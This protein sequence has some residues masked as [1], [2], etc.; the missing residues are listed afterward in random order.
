MAVGLLC[1]FCLPPPPFSSPAPV[2]LCV[3]TCGCGSSG[4][5]HLQII[6]LIILCYIT[7]VSSPLRCQIVLPVTV[8][9]SIASNH[10][11]HFVFVPRNNILHSMDLLVSIPWGA[12]SHMIVCLFCL[13]AENSGFQ[14]SQT[15]VPACLPAHQPGSLHYV[16]LRILK[17]GVVPQ[18]LPLLALHLAPDRKTRHNNINFCPTLTKVMLGLT[19]F[20]LGICSCCQSQKPELNWE[21]QHLGLLLPL[22]GTCYRKL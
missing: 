13:V 2:Y 16:P 10:C 20:G 17:N 12:P 1:F 3:W 22:P 15:T 4:E 7:P 11:V 19:I 18:L 6:P 21:R 9:K 5:A 8:T 14:N